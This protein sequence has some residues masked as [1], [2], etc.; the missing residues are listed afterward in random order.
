MKR[1]PEAGAIVRYSASM[2]AVGCDPTM[3]FRVVGYC[4]CGP[5]AERRWVR[6][7]DGVS[8]RHIAI[9]GI[10]RVRGGK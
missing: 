9:A 4:D 5:C 3:R 1:A 7:H 8:E 6:I 2:L 10:E